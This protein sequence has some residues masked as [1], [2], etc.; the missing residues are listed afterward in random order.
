M[1][2]PKRTTRVLQE[3]VWLWA[4]SYCNHTPIN[5][6]CN[7]D[8]LPQM[9]SKTQVTPVCIDKKLC[10]YSHFYI[11]NTHNLS[12]F[13]SGFMFSGV[14]GVMFW[15]VLQCLCVIIW[16]PSGIHQYCSYE[17]AGRPIFFF[18]LVCMLIGTNHLPKLLCRSSTPLIS[19]AHNNN[20]EPPSVE[21]VAVVQNCL[22][23]A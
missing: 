17:M 14:N 11:K 2:N 7:K 12:T 21:H 20:T 5:R 23:T 8:V 1:W 15:T 6:L 16:F 19:P 13:W 3:P 9:E 18:L 10:E 4:W 22:W